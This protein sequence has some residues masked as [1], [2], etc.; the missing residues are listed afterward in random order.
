M[1]NNI[2]LPTKIYFSDKP[3]MPKSS[4]SDEENSIKYEIITT[5]KSKEKMVLS[6]LNV[7][8]NPSKR[9]YISFK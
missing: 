9:K 4:L 3:L 7:L 5:F 1:Q 6:T 2:I 8:N